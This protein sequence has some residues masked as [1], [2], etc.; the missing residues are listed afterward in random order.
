[1]LVAF[2]DCKLPPF[3]D[4]RKDKKLTKDFVKTLTF[5][6]VKGFDFVLSVGV[7]IPLITPVMDVS[8]LVVLGKVVLIY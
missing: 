7:T 6:L 4:T 2:W 3:N 1:M 5:S 8:V